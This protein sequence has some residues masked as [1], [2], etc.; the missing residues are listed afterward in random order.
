MENEYIKKEK[1]FLKITYE[2]HLIVFC[3]LAIIYFMA[4][5]NIYWLGKSILTM[6]EISIFIFLALF[7][8]LFFIYVLF[9]LIQLTQKVIKFYIKISL[10]LFFIVSFNCLFCSIIS[11][12]NSSLF[13]TFFDDCPFNFENDL[14]KMN[15]EIIKNNK[16]TKNFCKTRKCF[17]INEPN[18][19]LCNF[20]EEDIYYNKQSILNSDD[21]TVEIN[22]FI[23]HC[24]NYT[25]FYLNKKR[26]YTNFDINYSSSC[27]SK[28]TIIY[29]YVLIYLFIVANIFCS[30]TLWLFEFCSYKIILSLLTEERN[31]DNNDMGLKETN[32][33]S[34]IENNDN[35]PNN[36]DNIS[37]LNGTEI[38]IVH[39]P[40]KDKNQSTSE[41]NNDINKDISKSEDQ[42]MNN[43]NNNIFKLI[44]QK[45]NIKKNE[46]KK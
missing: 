1:K 35:N 38:I 17:K 33:T 44:N 36:Q 11:C 31:N 39:N 18:I 9:L 40:N 16:T 30:P 37:Q 6:F 8:I 41:E 13:D 34:N 10:I 23:E 3:L 45:E 4:W 29:N 25:S 24:K 21:M 43:I 32:N 14:E 26:Q 19:Y 15:N 46:Q 5:E 42:L 7:L 22:Y 27:P 12:Y 28:S 2:I 20:Y